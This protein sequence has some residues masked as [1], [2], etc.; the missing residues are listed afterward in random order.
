MCWS[1]TGV[2]VAAT[3]DSWEHTVVPRLM[4]AGADLS[5]VYRVD[6]VTTEGVDTSLS[7]PN[8]SV[9]LKRVA[10]E[11]EAALVIL[12]PLISRLDTR[13]DTHKDADVRTALEPLVAFAEATS[14]CVLGLI[15]VNKSASNDV[16]TTLMAS[17]AFT[18]VARAVLF[19]MLDPQDETETIRL[20]GQAKNNLGRTDLPT[21]TFRIVGVRVADS[22]EGEVWTG[23]LEWLG[24]TSQ[25][26]REVLD[27]AGEHG[28]R[29]AARQAADWLRDYLN[30][31]GGTCDSAMV[32][33]EGKKAGYPWTR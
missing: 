5:R 8:D 24:Q 19:V 27:D 17:R 6:V 18:A 33:R 28:D 3:E 13:L 30:S 25:S 23:K 14:T 1:S 11:V 9:A 22:P 7:L 15:H 2:I 16:L 12:D 29:T 20:L 31:H 10:S 26:L 32:K 4:A 21:L